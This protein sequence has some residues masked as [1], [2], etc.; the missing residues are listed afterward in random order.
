MASLAFA[1]ID[2]PL[3]MICFEIIVSC[4]SFDKYRLN[5]TILAAKS[6]DFSNTTLQKKK[7][8]LL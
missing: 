5:F 4:F 8:K 6:N 1:P 2:V 3:L 7:K